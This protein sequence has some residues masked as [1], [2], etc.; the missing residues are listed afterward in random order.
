M[1][2]KLKILSLTTAL[3]GHYA[4]AQDT[5]PNVIF[6][7][8]DDLGWH[9]P[10]CCGNTFNETPNIDRL[11]QN[12]MRFAR[13][14]SAAP[15][16]SPTRASLM[17]GQSPKLHGITN[18]IDKNQLDIFLDTQK[19]V[20]LPEVFVQNG[21][22]TGMIGKWHLSVNFGTD[23][24]TPHSHGFQ[25]VALT[26]QQYI[27]SGDYFFPCFFLP[28]AQ[29]SEG[30]YLVDKMNNEAVNFIRQNAQKPFLLYLSHYAVHTTLDAPDSLVTKYKNKPGSGT[31]EN[32][33]T[34]AAML[35]K[36]DEGVGMIYAELIKQNL[37]H[38]TIIIFTS[39][40]GGES[41][42]TNNTPL[43]GAKS[44]IFEGGIRVPMVISWDGHI[45]K[46]AVNH[47]ITAT[48]DWLPTLCS[49]CNLSAGFSQK[50]DGVDISKAMLKNKSIDRQPVVWYYPLEKPHF[51]GGR[52]SEAVIEGDYKLIH[53]LDKGEWELYDLKTDEGETVN[54]IDD[55]PNKA[56]RMGNLLHCN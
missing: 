44:S 52:S 38:N 17:T 3:F 20:S 11:A 19:S 30:E 54:L 42:V 35:E 37:L 55:V 28:D 29:A 12:G 27:A 6:I 18:Y 33:P 25:H 21:Y 41:R 14:Y 1:K 23:K 4:I 39:D 15:V 43:R 9:E 8:T 22:T 2:N 34:L 46:G 48:Q 56:R 45:E 24:G 47:T 53:F 16:S 10:G 7:L 13:A 50:I 49:L 26:E 36:I 5:R 51:L 32:N 40:N 31:N